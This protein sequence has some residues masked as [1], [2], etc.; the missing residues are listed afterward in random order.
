MHA[1]SLLSN[2]WGTC[3]LEQAIQY[4]IQQE[5][6]E[7][8]ADINKADGRGTPMHVC[9]ISIRHEILLDRLFEQPIQHTK[10]DESSFTPASNRRIVL[11]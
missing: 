9:S 11:H 7:S 1:L 6:I 5:I 8:V 2:A 10:A 4:L 3:Y